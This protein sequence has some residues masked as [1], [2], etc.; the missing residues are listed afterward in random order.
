MRYSNRIKNYYID[1]HERED[2]VM[3]RNLFVKEY[4]QEEMRMHRWLQFPLQQAVQLGLDVETGYHYK[5]ETSGKF[6][7]FHV[8]ANERTQEIANG[9]KFGGNLS[10]RFP[11]G[12]FFTEFWT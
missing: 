12:N 6:V 9:V 5:A 4:L 2:V 3:S 10:V 11:Q 1:G 7:E 8:D